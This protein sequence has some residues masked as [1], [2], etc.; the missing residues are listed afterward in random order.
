MTKKA[1]PDW[2]AIERDYRTS[3]LSNAEL[4][5]KHGGVV[6]GQRI[7]QKAKAEGWQKDLTEAIRVA[8]KAKLI[9]EE[10]A[11]RRAEGVSAA[12]SAKVSTAF[13]ESAN[14]VDVASELGAAVVKRHRSDIAQTR[15]VALALLGELRVVTV[16]RDEL[17]RLLELAITE[18]MDEQ[19]V[20][21]MRESF[22][23]LIGLNSRVG[24]AQ[25][26]ADTLTKLQALERKAFDLD[27]EADDKPKDNE[28][29]GLM[30]FLREGAGRIR[31]GG[32]G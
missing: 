31:P 14:A 6:S 19:Q 5:R 30:D 18:D 23:K 10:V 11:K 4:S 26:L 29:T 12:V 24:S 3:S 9:Q 25:K 28:L 2:E 13:S 7:G 1:K 17:E 22:R 21:A 8:T 32:A 16:H 27:K 20:D 15:D